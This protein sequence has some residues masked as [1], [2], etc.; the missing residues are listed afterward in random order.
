MDGFWKRLLLVAGSTVVIVL[1]AVV[2][3]RQVAK[4]DIREFV[5]AG[6]YHLEAKSRLSLDKVPYLAK[7]SDELS[8]L[9]QHIAKSV[10]CID[11]AGVQSVQDV[12]ESGNNVVTQH[13]AVRGLG[14][15]VIVSQE[16]HILTNYHVVKG[17]QAI[18]VKL[19]DGT[20]LPVFKV[21]ED[22]VLDI[23]VLKIDSHEKF[24]ALPFGVSNHV[25]AGEIVLACGNPYGLG[26]SVSHGIVSAPQ[27]V[28][29]ESKQEW[30]QTDANISPGNSGGPLVNIKGEII[31]INSA[32]ES[33]NGDSN[34]GVGFAIP[35]NVAV[36]AFR[37]I[38]ERG[39]VAR[40]YLGISWIANSREMQEFTGN[41]VEGGA[42]VNFVQ[43]GSPAEKAGMRIN[44]LVVS[45]NGNTVMSV[46][47]LRNL[48]EGYPIGHT[49]KMEV[50]RGGKKLALEMTVDD[51]YMAEQKFAGQA[52]K[53]YPEAMGLSMRDLSSEE[54]AK[55]MSGVWIT[56][57]QEGTEAA[58]K[59][60]P[61]DLVVALN[62][63]SVMELGDIQN[64]AVLDGRFSLR[65]LRGKDYFD[66]NVV[67]PPDVLKR[68]RGL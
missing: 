1:V 8:T 7:M 40:G 27:R 59:F 37:E 64:T 18:S 14:S 54:R 36:S 2:Y 13:V 44:D 66:V 31:G 49:V 61:G 43:P 60:M 38:C 3:W 65:I 67:I 51:L 19:M 53:Y 28:Y 55:G 42:I 26:L 30:I 25:K 23:A 20:V 17:K 35:S 9:S 11:T 46:P 6:K 48:L 52:S 24:D 63:E 56:Q 62:G 57:V 16:G 68:I 21:G 34:I 10:V 12:S 4:R 33:R 45:V 50:V 32:V 47:R 58:T 39:Y 41:K 29:G 5:E 15:G 22:R